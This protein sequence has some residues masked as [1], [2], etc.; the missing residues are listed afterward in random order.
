MRMQE[1]GP[2]GTME[3]IWKSSV[4]KQNQGAGTLSLGKSDE[5]VGED[6]EATAYTAAEN[7]L[8]LDDVA[9]AALDEELQIKRAHEGQ[10]AEES[11]F[12]SISVH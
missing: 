12:D 7:E 10:A 11:R 6:E 3:P 9:R 5:N 8:E 2:K 4:K 1:V